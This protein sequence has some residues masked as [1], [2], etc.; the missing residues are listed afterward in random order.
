MNTLPV[1]IAFGASAVL[2]SLFLQTLVTTNRKIMELDRIN[3]MAVAKAGSS[4][5]NAMR[6]PQSDVEAT[7]YLSTAKRLLVFVRILPKRERIMVFYSNS[8]DE[9][10]IVDV[11]EAAERLGVGLLERPVRTVVELEAA[12]SRIKSEGVDGIFHIADP[13]VAAHVDLLLEEAKRHKIPTMTYDE[14]YIAKGALVAYGINPPSRFAEELPADM[15]RTSATGERL[16][17]K[18][19]AR[20]DLVLNLATANQIGF[21]FPRIA[22]NRA[23]KIVGG[24]AD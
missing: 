4:D 7:S 10:T 22:L 2:A 9:S 11:R 8:G 23:D 18:R 6:L 12:L 15:A 14:S 13:L 5:A 20:H 16:H 1:A 3:N 21:H 24:E 19:T 17:R